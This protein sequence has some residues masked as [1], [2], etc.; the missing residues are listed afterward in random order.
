MANNAAPGYHQ[1]MTEKDD[2]LA[3][4]IGDMIDGGG[5]FGDEALRILGVHPDDIKRRKQ[6]RR[7]LM[8]TAIGTMIVLVLIWLA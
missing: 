6:R 2:K 4:R 5:A 3:K 1:I 7:A 8:A